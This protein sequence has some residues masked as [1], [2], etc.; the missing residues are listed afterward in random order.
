[1]KVPNS[2]EVKSRVI[3]GDNKT[4]NNCERAVPAETNVTFL[5]NSDLRN[6]FFIFSVIFTVAKSN[7][8]KGVVN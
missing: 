8:S 4:P 2:S 6:L 3:T 5:V 7:K 1:M